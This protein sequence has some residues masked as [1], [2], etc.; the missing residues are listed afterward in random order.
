MS[1]AIKLPLFA[2]AAFLALGLLFTSGVVQTL[3]NMLGWAILLGGV[4][5]VVVGC[6]SLLFRVIVNRAAGAAALLGG[7]VLAV[8]G[9]FLSAMGNHQL[10][11]QRRGVRAHHRRRSADNRRRHRDVHGVPQELFPELLTLDNQR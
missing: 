9:F 6:A 5:L 3:V 7:V 11:Y 2:G 1:N 8:V 4:A 10:G